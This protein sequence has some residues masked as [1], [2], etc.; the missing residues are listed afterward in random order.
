[1]LITNEE[2]CLSKMKV[3]YDVTIK[4]LQ[5]EII[6]LCLGVSDLQKSHTFAQDDSTA[7]KAA[8][9]A[10]SLAD[11]HENSTMV[12]R[13]EKFEKNKEELELQVDDLEN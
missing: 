13:I 2:C 3:E 1:M 12:E 11:K 10:Q 6:E 9:D 7:L 4:N 5:T 8:K